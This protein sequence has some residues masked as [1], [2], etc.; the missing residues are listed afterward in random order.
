MDW[1]QDRCCSRLADESEGLSQTTPSSSRLASGVGKGRQVHFPTYSGDSSDDRNPM[2]ATCH[3][4]RL[5]RLQPLQACRL[6]SSARSPS[7]PPSLSFPFR[8]GVRMVRLAE[9]SPALPPNLPAFTCSRSFQMSDGLAC[10]AAAVR[11]PSKADSFRPTHL[12][13][14]SSA[15]RRASRP[16]CCPQAYRPAVEPGLRRSR[17]SSCTTDRKSV[18]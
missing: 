9:P 18:V 5:W 3:M 2:E 13:A 16:T 1:S 8:Q 14:S 17:L 12:Q 11:L 6:F 7:N 15:R 4:R 10:R